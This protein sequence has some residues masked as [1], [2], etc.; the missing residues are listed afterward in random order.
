MP[1]LSTSVRIAAGSILFLSL[2]HIVSWGLL[3]FGVFDTG[4]NGQYAMLSFAL[5]LITLGGFAGVLVAV[6][7]FKR[8]NWARVA[9]LTLA[10]LVACVC[11][12]AVVVLCALLYVGPNLI[13][14]LIGDFSGGLI[15]LIFLYL[16][17]L[18]LAIWWLSLL[19]RPRIA[20]QFAG[21]SDGDHSAALKKPVCPPPIA[22][23]AWLM[24][25][26]AVLSALCGLLVDGAIPA[27]LFT[28][29]FSAHAS[30]W[31]WTINIA[32]LLLCGIGLLRLLRWSYSVT[33]AFHVFWLVSIF[34]SQISPL[35]EKYLGMCLKT[36]MLPESYVSLGI[37]RFPHWV[38]AFATAIPTA[39]LIVGLFYYRPAFLK[40]AAE[41]R[42]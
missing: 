3:A 19:S 37:S 34:V 29:I 26:S 12:F 14:N 13:S 30:Q 22:L 2:A 20:E 1:R 17:V 35:Y 24:I 11:T 4:L 9:A 25:V 10:A 5:C 33:I 38:S 18:C 41:S 6:G 27:M 31:I 36:L 32:I 28:H 23:L 15:R 42:R 8:K 40:A 7:I 21:E 16:F 39:L